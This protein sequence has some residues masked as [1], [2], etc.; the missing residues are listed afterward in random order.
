M[1]E[2]Q[3]A[4][5][6]LQQLE[7]DLERVPPPKGQEKG[8]QGLLLGEK[9]QIANPSHVPGMIQLCLQKEEV[10]FRQN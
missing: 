2:T 3:P 6:L 9:T 5:N 8:A 1:A 7:G 10:S 4:K